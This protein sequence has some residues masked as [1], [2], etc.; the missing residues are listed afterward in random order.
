MDKLILIILDGWGIG[1]KYPGNVIDL[2]DTPNFDRLMEDYPHSQLTASGEAVGLPAGQMGNSEVG[3]MNIGSG[4]IIFQD[5]SRI[6]NDI[7]S[8]KFFENQVLVDN[9][10]KAKENK[11]KLH[12][13]G[14]VSF[15]G[16][17]SHFNHLTSILELCKKLDFHDVYI[18]CFTDGRDVAPKSS[19]DDIKQ[20]K[21]YIDEIGI[22]KIATI[23]GRYYAMDRDKRWDRTELAYRAIAM[24]EGQTF[25][26]PL[27]YIQESYDKDVTDEFIVP[28]LAIEDGKAV[29]KVD[30]G[31]SLIFFNFRPDRA[32]QLTR[33]FVDE[34]F[35]GFMRESIGDL[36]FVTMTNYD[37]TIKNVSVAYPKESYKNTLGEL[38]SKL[39]HKQ[40]RIA[41]TEKY[42]HVTF[43]FNGGKEEENFGED[44]ILIPSPK[45]KTYDLKP[46]MSAIEVKDRV[47]EAI[48]S[49]KYKLIILNFANT[50]MVGHTGVIESDKVAVETVDKCL[51]EILQ[52]VDNHNYYAL[53]T[54]DHGNSEYLIDEETNQPFTAHTTNPVPFIEYPDKSLKL[55]DGILADIAPTIL[56]LLEIEKPEEMT[57]SSLI[58]RG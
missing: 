16:V 38:V 26:D 11:K 4:R 8:K 22:G 21:E 19:I 35:D 37:D 48:N 33:A 52:A 51:G 20:L 27:E 28:G 41:E 2:A 49:D 43:F 25:S 56:D 5:L 30:E 58:I 9:I 47:V 18:H 55:K 23:S 6:N 44:R 34:D 57:G 53:V 32:R 13:M 50:D 14:L 42:A 10:L 40:L 24:G 3:H 15:G 39:G 29:S 31:D 45:V 7:E 12:L 17:H 46:E 1:K 54:A 36:S